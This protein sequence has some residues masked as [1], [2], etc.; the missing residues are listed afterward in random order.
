[1]F[2]PTGIGGDFYR[3]YDLHENKGVPINEN[4][5]AVAMERITG[6]FAGITLLIISFL[7]GM[8]SYMPKNA[9]ISLIA[10]LGVTLGFFIVLFFPRFFKIDII[11][12]KMKFTKRAHP[13]LK[14]FHEI[15]IS[16]RNKKKSVFIAFCYSVLI[17]TIFVTSYYCIG[18]SLGINISYGMMVF[19]SPF[20]SVVTSLPIALGGIG[21]RENATVFV[22]ENFGIST[23]DAT[24]FS[25]IVLSIILFNSLLGGLVYV[26]KNIFYKSKGII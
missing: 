3:V 6:N 16:Y 7:L 1:M 17:Q 5:S 13:K 18:R 26:L 22:L 8:F 4:I 21:L 20:A 19:T 9:V 12:K 23:G 25:F 15:L 24:V 14:S 2:L 11:L 10:I